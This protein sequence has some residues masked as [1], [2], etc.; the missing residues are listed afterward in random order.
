MTSEINNVTLTGTV[1]GEASL[2]ERATTVPVLS[3]ALEQARGRNSD[4]TH[5]FRC[6]AFGPLA[7]SAR[8]VVAEGS[9]VLVV[10]EL[11][12]VRARDFERRGRP[13]SSRLGGAM[14][15]KATSIRALGDQT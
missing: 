5:R 14:E 11:N 3:F 1:V 13:G 2:L 8:D 7:L 10:G 9:R 12:E 4:V 6:V 15:V